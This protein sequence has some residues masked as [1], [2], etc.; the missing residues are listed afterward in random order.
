M[1][2]VLGKEE[3]HDWEGEQPGAGAV[4]G[5]E[6]DWEREGRV[7]KGVRASVKDRQAKAMR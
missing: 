2:E 1:E 4:G 5:E 3:D 6:G 7:G